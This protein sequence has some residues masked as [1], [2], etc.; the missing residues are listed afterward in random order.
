M[1]KVIEVTDYTL[2][3]DPEWEHRLKAAKDSLHQRTIPAYIDFCKEVHE[4]R[5]HCDSSQG[6]SEF[7]R[8]GCEWLGCESR[9]IHYWASVGKRAD[10]LCSATAKLP[11]SEHAI[12]LIASLDD[13]AFPKALEKLE[14]DMTQAQVKDLIKKVNPPIE[15]KPADEEST[16]RKKAHKII[17]EVERLPR[18]FQFIVWDCIRDLFN[19]AA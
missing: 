17:E 19:E 18:K 16:H 10:E 11:I 13:I 5:L 1:G 7:S 9:Q 8:K 4:F 2:V 3:A 6:G 12:S 14:P 15:R